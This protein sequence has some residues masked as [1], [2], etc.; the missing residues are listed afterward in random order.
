MEN[1]HVSIEEIYQIPGYPLYGNQFEK[2]FRIRA[3]TTREEKIRL[4]APGFKT[5]ARVIQNC[6]VNNQ[7][8]D[9]RDLKLFDF[10]YL[11]FKVRTITYGPEYKINIMCPY[12]G[13]RMDASIDLDKLKVNT[14]PEDFKEP[15][16]IGPLPIS[17]DTLECKLFSLRDY[18]DVIDEAIE[19]E[20]NYP[21]YDGDPR[22]VLD[23]CKR[24]VSVNGK[25]PDSV[26]PN[27]RTYIEN[28]HARDYQYFSSKYEEIFNSF[29]IDAIVNLK[30]DSCGGEYRT[31]LP[32]TDEFF[33][34]TY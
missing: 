26:L 2:D 19:F 33:R 4:S 3:M 21:E 6:L 8:V 12:C 28:M 20:K 25:S 11:M 24:V 31:K 27:L 9:V 1:N 13:K 7:D 14:V 10:Q 23:L 17:K 18:L 30:C 29:G 22:F 34:P 5:L 16:R 15:I 32:M